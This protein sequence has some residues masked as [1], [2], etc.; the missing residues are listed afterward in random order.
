M[1]ESSNIVTEQMN[2]EWMKMY[3]IFHA[4]EVSLLG[5]SVKTIKCQ[6]EIRYR[7]ANVS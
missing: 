1:V 4:V 5:E 6:A 7:L 2:R 3:D